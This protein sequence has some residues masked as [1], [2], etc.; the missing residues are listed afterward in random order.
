[1]NKYYINIDLTHGYISL[2]GSRNSGYGEHWPKSACGMQRLA[3]LK[4]ARQ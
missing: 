3:T 4:V 1:M 2:Y